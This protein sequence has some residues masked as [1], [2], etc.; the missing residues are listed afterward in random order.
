VREGLP[1]RYCGAPVRFVRL[2]GGWVHTRPLAE[3]RIS[4]REA[5]DIRNDPPPARRELNRQPHIHPAQPV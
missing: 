2:A 3:F 5:S 1:C 4:Q